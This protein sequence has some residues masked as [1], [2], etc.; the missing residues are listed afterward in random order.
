MNFYQIGFIIGLLSTI[1]VVITLF[2]LLQNRNKFKNMYQ[3]IYDRYKDVID[4]EAYKENVISKTN[5]IINGRDKEIASLDA[6][7][8]TPKFEF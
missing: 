8:T 6:H 3:A 7:I 5:E 4:L 1:T 2:L